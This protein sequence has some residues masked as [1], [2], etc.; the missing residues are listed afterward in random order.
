MS[1]IAGIHHKW[2]A[3]PKNATFQAFGMTLDARGSNRTRK[4]VW[5]ELR[6][7]P[8]IWGYKSAKLPAAPQ[9]HL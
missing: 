9:F 7:E 3:S 4:N 2:T 1:W 6:V 5:S 8:G